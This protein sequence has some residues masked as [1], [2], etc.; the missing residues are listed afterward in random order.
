LTTGLVV[1]LGL[2]S[3]L[4]Q[5]LLHLERGVIE[6]GRE[7]VHAS[8]VSRVWVGAYLGPGP[9]QREYLNAVV[10]A[11]T[12][13]APLELLGRT[14]R[15][16]TRCGRLPGTHLQP[17]ALDIDILF[18]GGWIIRSP[19]LVVPHPRLAARRFVLEPL[20]DVAGLE[21]PAWPGLAARLQLLRTR[22]PL[23]VHAALRLRVEDREAAHT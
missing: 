10:E 9:A 3:N 5:R 8:R 11:H 23:Q 13:L 19:R 12:S 14:Q 1:H 22:Q 15:V 21:N 17:R 16:E 20:H 2:G 4:G 6:L 7:G 18:Y